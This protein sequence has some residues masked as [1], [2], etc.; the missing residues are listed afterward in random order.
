MA[1]QSG[2]KFRATMI[3]TGLLVSMVGLSSANADTVRVPA[4]GISAPVHAVGTTSAGIVIPENPQHVGW[5]KRSARNRDHHGSSIL[6]G[7]VSD[8]HL[9]RGVFGKLT[10]TKVG[11]VVIWE[12]GGVVKR[13]RI[14]SKRKYLRS[15]ALPSRLFRSTGPHLLRM[16]TCT[17]LVHMPDGY[18]HYTK[19]LV[20]TAREISR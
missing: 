18:F 20:V 3:L 10:H 12:T 9:N 1:A 13:Y 17:N 14:V 8:S 15:R 4:A 2:W 6:V 7:H 11:Q 19:N 16:I 5:W